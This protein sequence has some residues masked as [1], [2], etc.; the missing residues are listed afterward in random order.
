MPRTLYARLAVV[1]VV[2]VLG[3]ALVY[4]ALSISAS[5]HYLTEANQKLS[6]DLAKNLVMDRDLVKEGRLDEARLKDTFKQYM[7]INPGIE[8]YLLDR[9]GTILSFSADPGKVKRRRV[10]LAPIHAFLDGGDYPL[11]GDDPRS[12]ERRK[13]FSVTPVPTAENPQGYLYVVLQGE[14]FDSV[15]RAIGDNYFIHLGLWALAGSLL[16][17]LCAGLLM[18][19]LLTR[20][21]RRLSRAMDRFRA[22]GF[23]VQQAV[24][25]ETHPEKLDEIGR[26]GLSFDQ[27]A[28]R[29]VDQMEELKRQD[30]VR[31]DMVAQVSHDLRTPLATLHGY[32]ETLHI[33]NGAFAAKERKEYIAI[34]LRHS[35]RLTRLVAEL[36]ELAKLDARDRQLRTEPFSI[37]ELVQDVVQKFQLKARRRRMYLYHE[38]GDKLPFVCADIGLIERALENLLD[39]ALEHGTEGNR[40]CVSL[41]SSSNGVQVQVADSGPGIAPADQARIFD[42]FYQADN[43]HRGGDHAGLGLAIVKRILELHK[44][45]ISVASRRGEGTRFVFSLTAWRNG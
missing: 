23:A 5:W 40:I 2:L 14:E 36:F 10:S 27:M 20:R 29:I 13:A 41:S 1:L 16:F 7:T 18:F 28:A 38:L 15:Y 21:L 4:V 44:A 11:L 33:R 45:D 30:Q 24:A 26:L 39:N 9:R 17:G 43:H 8:I 35:E 42:R 22:S 12:H 31:R 32:L 37:A 25:G 3:I 6:R 19:H 34:A